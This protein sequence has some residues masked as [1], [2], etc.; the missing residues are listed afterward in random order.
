MIAKIKQWWLSMLVKLKPVNT[1]HEVLA[2]LSDEVERLEEIA[3]F[4]RNNI[5]ELETDIVAASGEI[6]LSEREMKRAEAVSQ[7]LTKL[8]VD[9]SSI[10]LTELEKEI[11][12]R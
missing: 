5:H 3:D 1:V 7:L 12:N 2:S 9:G 10:N 11:E 6:A 4:H 8:I